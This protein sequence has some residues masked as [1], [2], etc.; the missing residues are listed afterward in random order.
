[1]SSRPYRSKRQR[2]CD[3]CRERKLGCQT[4]A[5]LPCARCRSADLRCTFAKPP[6][7]RPRRQLREGDEIGFTDSVDSRSQSQV[8]PSIEGGSTPSH[9]SS[10][11]Q[12][13]QQQ[14]TQEEYPYAPAQEHLPSQPPVA[15]AHS[16]AATTPANQILS[17]SWPQQLMS[18]GRAPTQFVQSLDQLE[19]FSAQLFGASA[20]SDPWLL[21]HCSFDDAG[22]KCFYKVHF[23]NA[24]GVPVPLRIPVHFM[25]AADDLA[26]DSKTETRVAA[27]GMNP[28]EE[29]N[30]LVP[31]EYG[32][33]LVGLYVLV[34][35][36]LI[37]NTLL[38]T[39]SGLSSTSGL[40]YRWSLVTSLA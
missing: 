27:P 20:E 1:M 40:H 13:Q 19:G 18:S 15:A 16:S 4:E 35:V 5:G 24:G 12:Q 7:K 37:V 8:H 25:I 14:Q 23:R 17:S 9:P 22:V 26:A 3:Q 31:D 28:R 30:S 2:P 32:V 36:I 39:D 33:R 21:R 38:T 6:P 29:L 34:M 10:Q 11:H